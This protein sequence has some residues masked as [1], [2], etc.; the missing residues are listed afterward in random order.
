MVAVDSALDPDALAL[1]RS[2]LE[3]IAPRAPRMWPAV[4]AALF[5]A[6]CALSLAVAM[7]IAPPV[8]T[9]HSMVEQELR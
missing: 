7:V 8:V 2:L 9:D 5:A 6:V 4:A 1:A 3:P